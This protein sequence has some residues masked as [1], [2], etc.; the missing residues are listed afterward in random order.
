[1]N[2][3]KRPVSGGQRVRPQVSNVAT[4]STATTSTLTKQINGRERA[5]RQDNLVRSSHSVLKAGPAS[6]KCCSAATAPH[7]HLRPHLRA[8]VAWPGSS[9]ARLAADLRMDP[10]GSLGGTASAAPE[11]DSLP[12]AVGSQSSHVARF[13]TSLAQIRSAYFPT[14]NWRGSSSTAA[15]SHGSNSKERAKLYVT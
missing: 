13:G 8:P 1:M 4:A 9:H 5:M 3:T 2:T 14:K 11:C 6:R 15:D 10:M 12:D 7:R